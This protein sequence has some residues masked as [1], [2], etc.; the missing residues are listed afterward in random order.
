MTD[1]LLS[2]WFL[3]AVTYYQPLCPRNAQPELNKLVIN[4]SVCFYVPLLS[5]PP[6]LHCTVIWIKVR[7]RGCDWGG[8]ELEGAGFSDIWKLERDTQGKGWI[9]KE[10]G[11]LQRMSRAK[12]SR[13]RVTWK[14]TPEAE[15]SK[16]ARLKKRKIGDRGS[17]EDRIQEGQK[18]S[19]RQNL[20]KYVTRMASGA[21]LSFFPNVPWVF[22]C[23]PAGGCHCK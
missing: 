2:K 12:S 17:W 3:D 1:V 16:R 8:R 19:K 5:W 22:K 13:V 18:K 14:K 15:K 10:K 23:S 20:R 7:V 4:L 21:P 9:G 6:W 11:L